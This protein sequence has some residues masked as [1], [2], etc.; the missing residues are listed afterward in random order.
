MASSQSAP[1]R[2]QGSNHCYSMESPSLW[3]AQQSPQLLNRGGAPDQIEIAVQQRT[4]DIES[5]IRSE[6][7]FDNHAIAGRGKQKTKATATNHKKKHAKHPT[8]KEYTKKPHV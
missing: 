5:S 8:H 1:A 6:S 7:Q 4:G 3:L 2:Q